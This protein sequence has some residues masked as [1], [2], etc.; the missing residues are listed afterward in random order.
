MRYKT[1]LV[2]PAGLGRS[3]AARVSL[4]PAASMP[5]P[6]PPTQWAQPLPIHLPTTGGRVPRSGYP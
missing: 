4:V 2:P 3:T 1:F 5:A 6:A